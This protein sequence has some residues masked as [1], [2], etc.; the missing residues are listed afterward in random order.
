MTYLLAILAACANATSSVLQRKASR[1]IPQRQ[2]L[3][4]RLIWSL[5]HE[6]V[7]FGGVLAVT[8]GFLLQAAALGSGQLS[9]V[10]PILVLELPATLLL[11][12]R[13]FH[14]RL[15]R[16]EWGAAVAMAAGLAAMLY[17]LSP[18]AG[19]SEGIRWY[20]WVIGIGVNMAFVAAMVAWGRRGPAG[21]GPRSGQSSARQAA[22]LAV[23]AGAT[24]GLTA[25]LIK[26]VTNTFSQGIVT[27]LTSWQLYAMVAAGIGG[28]FLLQSAMNAGR[29]VA[30]QPGL[31]LTDPIVSIL[32]GVL[33][34]HEQVRTG[35]FLVLTAAGGLVITGAVLVLAR[36]PL[37]SS[38]S[39]R[40]ERPRAEP[41]SSSARGSGGKR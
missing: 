36:S 2:N 8:I 40:D 7:W 41:A 25:A 6:P 35:W 22:V 16:R 12:T 15:H 19:R 11:A 4:P 9:V 1:E 28:M 33:V 31:T 20:A 5:L 3:S 18:S 26:G 39:G 21:G 14:A 27:L 34:F 13:V 30:A 17:A 24:F 37:L 32:W 23:G 10:E 29:L 38:E